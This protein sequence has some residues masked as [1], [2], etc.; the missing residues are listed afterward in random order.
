MP[1]YNKLVRDRIPEII[2][3]DGKRL[4]TRILDEDEYVSHLDEKL[5]EELAEYL[6]CEETK[7]QIEELADM[8]EVI[9]ALAEVKGVT[10]QELEAVRRQKADKRGAFNERIL[11]EWVED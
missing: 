8:L 10:A 4:S 5:K 6:K 11:L 2:E 9:L 3:R 7:D 1:H